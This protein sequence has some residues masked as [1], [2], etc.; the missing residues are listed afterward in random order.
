ML[1]MMELAIRLDF[2]WFPCCAATPSMFLLSPVT[3]IVLSQ[4]E[5]LTH[6][7]ILLLIIDVTNRGNVTMQCIIA[8]ANR[9]TDTS[10]IQHNVTI[11]TMQCNITLP[12]RCAVSI[13]NRVTA[14]RFL[15]SGV[16]C[17]G[18][19]TLG[20]MMPMMVVCH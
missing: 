15:I 6:N 2:G 9:S 12:G 8:V 4:I 14:C 19:Q 20:C 18:I 1:M 7:M 16:F 13:I 17:I 10:T 11:I 3:N 5:P